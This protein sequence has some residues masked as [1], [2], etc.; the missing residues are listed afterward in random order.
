MDLILYYGLLCYVYSHSATGNP[1]GLYM[2]PWCVDA[3][4]VYMGPHLQYN[5]LTMNRP[6]VLL[7][8]LES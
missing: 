1:S 8:L 2:R 3:L 7:V 4:L 5:M 6:A